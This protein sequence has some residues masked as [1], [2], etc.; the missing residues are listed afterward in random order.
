MPVDCAVDGTALTVANPD[1]D[2]PAIAHSMPFY[3][4]DKLRRTAKG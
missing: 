3:D 4:V 1:G 2:I